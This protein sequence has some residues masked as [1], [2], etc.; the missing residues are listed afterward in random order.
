[1]AVVDNKILETL[2]R[3]FQGDLEEAVEVLLV[4][5]HGLEDQEHQVKAVM[6][7]QEV[8]L[9]LL[10]DLLVVGVLGL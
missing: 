7:E 2:V 3:G 10:M 4:H 8:Q 9:P 6:V 5:Q 1:V